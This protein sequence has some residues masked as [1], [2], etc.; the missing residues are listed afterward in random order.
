MI[1]ERLQGRQKFARSHHERIGSGIRVVEV[2]G[3]WQLRAPPEFEG[4]YDPHVWMDPA[5][6]ALTIDIVRGID[7]LNLF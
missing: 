1:D 7:D 3:G 5:R 2:G 6:W 4:N